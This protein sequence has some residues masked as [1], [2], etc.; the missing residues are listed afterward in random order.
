MKQLSA[1]PK[2]TTVAQR[3]GTWLRALRH[4][5]AEKGYALLP[6]FYP[7]ENGENVARRIGEIALITKYGP[8][9]ELTPKNKSEAGL[10]TYSGVYG[11]DVFPLHTDLAH[12]RNPP[13]FLMLRCVVG[14][15]TAGTL[16]LDGLTLLNYADK[17]LLSRS[18]VVPRRPREGK[19][20][21]MRLL[22]SIDGEFGLLRWDERFIEPASPTGQKGVQMIKSVLEILRPEVIALCHRGDTLV[23]DNWRIL[24]GR[25]AVLDTHSTRKLERV[26]LEAIN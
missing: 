14:F 6:S 3:E 20:H 11:T 13:H 23:I 17:D 16:L 5:I 2:E 10:N 19:I 25:S 15:A 8:V 7:N 26:Y 1:S 24:H 4:G 18:L 22:K 9:Q 12:W 21:L